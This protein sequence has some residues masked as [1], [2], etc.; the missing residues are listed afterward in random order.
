[1]KAAS[2]RGPICKASRA[3]GQRD[4]RR[5][6]R[7][8]LSLDMRSSASFSSAR[9]RGERCERIVK[10]SE[11]GNRSADLSR[12][13]IAMRAKGAFANGRSD[14]SALVPHGITP[15][16]LAEASCRGWGLALR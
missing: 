16:N 13:A 3:D 4:P 12:K 15:E 9:T 8:V 2:T 10:C 7:H 1:M 14:K 6:C 5:I 11:C